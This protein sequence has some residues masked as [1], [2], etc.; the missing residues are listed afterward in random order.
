MTTIIIPASETHEPIIK[1]TYFWPDIDPVRIREL[2]RLEYVVTPE[3]LREAIRMGI[4]EAN[5]EL[6]LFR[7]GNIAAG[8]GCLSE[9]PAEKIDGES[10]KSFH[11]LRAVS[12]FASASLYE[13]YRGYDTSGKGEK[14]A[15]A[16]ESTAD[17]L[18]RDARWAIC[19]LQGQPRAIIG[20]I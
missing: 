17:T 6:H 15:G 13:R 4:A 7:T 9:V 3:R 10:E 8:Y 14:K 19:R 2:M 18:W 12:A 20:Q 5:A 11:Y 16:L 1:N